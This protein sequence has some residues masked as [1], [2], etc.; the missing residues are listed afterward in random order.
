MPIPLL[1]TTV[2]TLADGSEVLYLIPLLDA[3]E[4]EDPEMALAFAQ[5]MVATLSD[6]KDIPGGEP[7]F[8][9]AEPCYCLTKAISTDIDADGVPLS[10]KYVIGLAVGALDTWRAGI[11]F[12]TSE[13]KFEPGCHYPSSVTPKALYRAQ[14][15]LMG[16]EQRAPES[17]TPHELHQVWG[18]GVES[19]EQGMRAR[20]PEAGLKIE[21][22]YYFARFKA[23][24]LLNA[25]F[26]LSGHTR[27]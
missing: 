6:G 21:P 16:V 1:S 9:V 7:L 23:R 14:L 26:A 2:D 5:A 4:L 17:L 3:S 15:T 27:T 19:F 20:Y 12:T 11:S 22:F 24:K 18:A 13:D 25:D 10:T 8:N